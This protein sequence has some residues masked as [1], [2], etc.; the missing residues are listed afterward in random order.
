MSL[1]QLR[2]EN[3]RLKEL[4]IEHGNFLL[5]LK[6]ENE[7]LKKDLEDCKMLSKIEDHYVRND[8]IEKG[9]EENGKD[10][11]DCPICQALIQ[12]YI[13]IGKNRR[14]K[15]PEC[16]KSYTVINE[17]NWKVEEIKDE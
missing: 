14:F 4:Y 17:D 1:N 10:E 9:L 3:V 8:L 11:I 13:E 15:C 5:Q 2:M 16:G 6:S 12:T 7:K